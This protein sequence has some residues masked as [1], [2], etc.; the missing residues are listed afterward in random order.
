MLGLYTLG[1]KR[2]KENIL[3]FLRHEQFIAQI[4]G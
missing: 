4:K 1:Y 2:K 3:D